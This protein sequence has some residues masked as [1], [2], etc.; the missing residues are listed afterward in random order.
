[1]KPHVQEC[2]NNFLFVNFLNTTLFSLPNYWRLPVLL[3]GPFIVIICCRQCRESKSKYA[4]E[5][6][7]SQL[8]IG[9]IIAESVQMSKYHKY[10]CSEIP[11][12]S[13]SCPYVLLPYIFFVSFQNILIINDI[14]ISFYSR[15]FN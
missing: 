3:R 12:L 8:D 13:F 6:V 1:M 5:S 11:Y 14:C 2:S 9:N 4:A 7:V 15:T 10:I